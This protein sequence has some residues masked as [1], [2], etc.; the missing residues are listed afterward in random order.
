[1]WLLNFFKKKKEENTSIVPKKEHL[2]SADN[3]SP[4]VQGLTLHADLKDLIWIWDGKHKNYKQTREENRSIDLNTFQVTISFINQE[5]PSLIYTNQVI[6]QI[7]KIKNVARPWYYPTYS[8]LSP[9]QKW[10]YLTLLANP[11]NPSIDIGFVFILYYGLERH[12]LS[13]NFEK[14][15]DV[16]LKLRDIHTNRSFQSYSANAIIL[17]CMLHQRGDLVLKFIASLDKEHEL[18]FSD[19]LFLICYF[20]F[21]LPLLPTDIMRMAKTFE[22]NNINYIKKYPDLFWEALKNVIR[23]KTGAESIDLKK[24]LTPSEIKKIKMQDVGI[25]A[26]M[27]IMEQSIPIPLLSENFKL[28][29]EMYHLLEAAHQEVKTQLS[30]MRKSGR[31]PLIKNTAAKDKKKLVFDQTQE[32]DLLTE[33]SRNKNNPINKHFTYI[34]LQDF[35]YKYRSL[36]EEYINKCIEY[37]ALDINALPEMVETYV[38]EEIKRAQQL[39]WYVE[40]KDIKSKIEKIQAE[41]FI[42]SIPA[43]KRLVIIF[44]KQKRYKKAIEI[45]DRAIAYGQSVEEFEAKKQK[46]H[47]IVIANNIDG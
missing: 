1:M 44:E 11:Y 34:K 31:P 16:I 33:L 5:E 45:C 29:R 7:Q 15:I 46:L 6:S 32:K 2:I 14:A 26:N 47:S 23:N 27:S 39:A 43:F 10:V 8:G 28:K 20:S 25:F 21:N 38:A 13:G 4:S 40:A 12:L 35:Y 3:E 9:E 19:N 36:G 30:E 24:Y 41:G 42:G 22:F 18:S 17:S 37:C